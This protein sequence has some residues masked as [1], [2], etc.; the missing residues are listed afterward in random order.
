M[1]EKSFPEEEQK[2]ENLSQPDTKRHFCT[3]KKKNDLEILFRSGRKSGSE[4]FKAYYIPEINDGFSYCVSAPKRIFK[5]AVD[6]NKCKRFM[7]EMIRDHSFCK[8]NNG[9]FLMICIN[10]NTLKTGFSEL[11]KDFS[12]LIDNYTI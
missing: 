8:E 1:V 9:E 7:R 6:R 10:K 11:K 12:F 4:F 2:E 5:R 3:L